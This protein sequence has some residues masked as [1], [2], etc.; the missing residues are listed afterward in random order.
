MSRSG[1]IAGRIYVVV[2]PDGSG[3]A[4]PECN[5]ILGKGKYA[6]GIMA[7]ERKYFVEHDPSIQCCG[8]D[9]SVPLFFDDLDEAVEMK[10]RV[11]R[12]DK[13]LILQEVTSLQWPT[14]N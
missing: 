10:Q 7:N 3:V 6:I 13:E 2:I 14:M 1:K 12:T 11:K 4:C 8:E 9:R 5:E